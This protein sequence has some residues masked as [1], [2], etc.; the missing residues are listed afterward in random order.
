MNIF[1][2]SAELYIMLSVPILFIFGGL[3]HFIYLFSG[4]SFIVGLVAPVNESV[5]EHTKMVP[6]P[7]YM[8]WGIYYFFN[9]HFLDL[10]I[11]IT[12][13]FVSMI[14]SCFFMIVLF[15]FYTGA[16][17][18]QYLYVDIMLLFVALLIGHAFALL[19]FKAKLSLGVIA[20]P[21]VIGTSLLFVLF[22]L[23]P[24]R[25]PVFRDSIDGQYGMLGK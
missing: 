17:G 21:L 10:D 12:A 23:I 18:V 11:W 22:T 15:Y 20:L 16:F 3:F 8:W 9:R 14:S 4:K 5:F 25:L 1:S 2:L 13:A 24:P 19:C 6:F 7:L